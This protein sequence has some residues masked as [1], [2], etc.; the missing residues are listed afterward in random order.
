MDGVIETAKDRDVFSIAAGP[1]ALRADVMPANRSPDV[2]IVVSLLNSAGQVLATDN[3]LNALN[4]TLTYNIPAQGTYYLEVKGTGE[5]D[6]AVTGYS[7]YGSVGNFRLSASYVAPEGTPP[8]AVISAMPNDGPAPLSVTLEGTQSHDDGQVV[9]W[10]WDFG[11]GNNDVTG[12]LSSVGH[13]Y[14]VAGNYLARLTVVDN[15]GL[16]SSTSQV[17]NVSVPAPQASVLS[18]QIA[19]K[20]NT[21]GLAWAVATV[22]VVDQFGKPL[23]GARVSANWN[24]IVVKATSALTNRYGTMNFTSPKTK[25]LGCFN[26]TV[27]NIVSS[28]HP[29][30][31][32]STRTSQAC[33]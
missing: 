16:S 15:T 14:Q 20:A 2:D 12:T 25:A 30:N 28:G 4:A 26:L 22:T 8:T 10:Y 21:R 11:D 33:R 24:G 29:F 3:P 6:P 27:T 13:I 31:A 7:N 5:G 9:F 17:I 1:G 23:R 18:I 19:Q 32:A